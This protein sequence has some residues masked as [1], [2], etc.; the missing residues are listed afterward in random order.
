VDAL[1]EVQ[2]EQTSRLQRIFIR[3][4]IGT[5]QYVLIDVDSNCIQEPDEFRLTN[6]SDGEY[7]L[8]NYPTEQLFPII[9]LRAS[10]RVRL[11]PKHL[12][13]AESTLGKLLSSVTGE[14]YLRVEEKSQ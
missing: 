8:I 10:A 2:T 7:T 4:P 6:A 11:E 1:Y 13:N 14:T 12:L 3:V 5:G 9:N